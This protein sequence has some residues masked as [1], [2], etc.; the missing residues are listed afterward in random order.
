VPYPGAKRTLSNMTTSLPSAEPH[1]ERRSQN[2]GASIS[3]DARRPRARGRTWDERGDDWT[4]EYAAPTAGGHALRER[5]RRL[6]ELLPVTPGRVL[7]AG[8]GSGVLAGDLVARG[9]QWIGLDASRGMLRA[10]R[11]SGHAR[12]RLLVASDAQRLPFPAESFD[13]IVCVGVI[14]GV[15]DADAALREMVRA[16]KP[17]GTLVV[18]WANRRSPYASW[19]LSWRK[20]L[21]VVRR[22]RPRA[23]S[24]RSG[25]RRLHTEREAA[26]RMR[27][28]GVVPR[29]AVYF[30][31]NPLAPPLDQLAPRLAERCTRR[32]ESLR[33]TRFAWLGA[34]F[35]V[36]ARR[37]QT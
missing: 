6:V 28:A 21:A 20:L 5:R 11:A 10:A 4:R 26:Q 31:F 12:E 30:Y 37:P 27:I 35:F 23:A 9:W 36:E 3:D 2:Q 33:T 24:N 13:A 18:S 7:D 32:L 19:S 34:G 16:L 15:P 17:G 14:D 22:E 8:C 29:P 25:K 1:A